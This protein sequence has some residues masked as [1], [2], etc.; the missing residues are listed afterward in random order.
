MKEH[1]L[2][3]FLNIISNYFNQFG[4][5]QVVVD[6]PYLLEK[7]QPRGF[8]YNSIITISGAQT[9][10]VHFSATRELLY[11]ILTSMGETDDSEAMYLDLT[12]EV[13]N[14]IAGN[15]RREFG[16]EFDISVPSVSKT[17]SNDS[18]LLNNERSFIIPITWLSQDGE[19][20][21]CLQE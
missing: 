1:G 18:A 3:V 21:V 6:T 13:A 2:Q 12:G 4:K 15:A 9:G 10:V 7:N 5:E 20:L 17:S 16:A 8:D 11:S 14:T 19:I